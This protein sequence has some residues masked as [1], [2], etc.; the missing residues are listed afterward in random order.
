LGPKTWNALG[1]RRP[2]LF[3][4]G[5]VF[6]FDGETVIAKVVDYFL[7]RPGGVPDG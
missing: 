6:V 3:G 1:L 5:L 4:I 2:S 7:V